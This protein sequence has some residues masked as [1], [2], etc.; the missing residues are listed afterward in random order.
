M[1]EAGQ[2]LSEI[3]P[4]GANAIFQRFKTLLHEG[5]VDQK[6]QYSI[7]NLFAIRKTSFKNHA[8]VIPELDLVE[9]ED[10][11]THNLDFQ[12][13]LTAEDNINIFKFDPFY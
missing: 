9:A 3:T 1:V 11:I 4:A 13:T 7:Q 12:D 5:E 10:Q 6:A 8:G 2:I